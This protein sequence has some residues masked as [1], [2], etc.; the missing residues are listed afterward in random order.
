M[1]EGHLH[2][3]AVPDVRFA[4]R[5]AGLSNVSG[6]TTYLWIGVKRFHNRLL[7]AEFVDEDSR[8]NHA[9]ARVFSA[10]LLVV[11]V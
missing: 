6:E 9:R 3:L 2:S 7:S 4:S 10:R 8:A 11:V 1:E 5:D